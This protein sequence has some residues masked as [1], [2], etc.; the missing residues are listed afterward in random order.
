MLS[1]IKACHLSPVGGHHNGVRSAHKILHCG[2]YWPIIHQD[3]QDFSK[4]C[5]FCHREGGISKRQ[6]LH[7]NLIMV[8]EL[9]NV[10]GYDFMGPFVSSYGMKYILVVVDYVVVGRITLPKNGGKSVT[11]FLKKNI[12]SRFGTPRE[13]INH[14]DY[15]FCNKWIKTLLDKHGVFLM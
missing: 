7:M 8:I 5:D 12:F 2:Y 4:S 10:W 15:H 6:D 1:F 3:A 11:A 13:I 9:F 14:G